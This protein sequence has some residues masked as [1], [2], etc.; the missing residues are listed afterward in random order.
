LIQIKSNQKP[1]NCINLSLNLSLGALGRKSAYYRVY[2]IIVTDD[3]DANM[4]VVLNLPPAVTTAVDPVNDNFLDMLVHRLDNLS[5]YLPPAYP[6]LFV[7]PVDPGEELLYFGIKE[8]YYNPEKP[9]R[10]YYCPGCGSKRFKEEEFPKGVDMRKNIIDHYKRKCNGI[11]A[12][13]VIAK[14]ENMEDVNIKLYPKKN[15]STKDGYIKPFGRIIIPKAFVT[16]AEYYFIIEKFQDK[17][18]DGKMGER[19]AKRDRSASPVVASKKT[20]LNATVS[21]PRVLH[22]E[23]VTPSSFNIFKYFFDHMNMKK[24][25]FG[26]VLI[27]EDSRRGLNSKFAFQFTIPET[28]V[29]REFI[30][31]KFIQFGVG[32]CI[33]DIDYWDKQFM[34]WKEVMH[35]IF[36]NHQL[37]QEVYDDEV[38]LDRL[39]PTFFKYPDFDT[40]EALVENT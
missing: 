37:N 35:L 1:L 16:E 34:L 12:A 18:W 9:F 20:T 7:P 27:Y 28:K 22:V 21:V 32:K 4:E 3:I 24:F 26:S 10:A 5:P 19:K 11:D 38:H 29:S 31:T 17:P 23:V 6:T 13:T 15:Y 8:F 33:T 36:W 30:F 25:S 40:E 14:Y 2:N 39:S